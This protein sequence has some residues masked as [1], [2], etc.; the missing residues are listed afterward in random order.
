MGTIPKVTHQIW[1]QGWDQLPEKYSKN[2]ESL[3]IL[4][5]NWEH[6][7]WDEKSLRTECEKF[8]P[9]ALA[10]FDG[11][12]HMMRKIVFGRYVVLHNYGGISID[13][14]A[15]CL[16]PLDKIP[17]IS[18]E[19]LIIS[20]SPFYGWEDHLSTRGL[21][22]DLIM[23]NCATIACTKKHPLM[24]QFIEFLIKNEL[25]DSDSQFEEH[26]QTGPLVT[27]VFFNNFLDEICILECEII[28]PGGIITRRTVINH[29]YELSWAHPM[30]R[31]FK[32]PYMYVRRNIIL[33][34]ILV[35]FVMLVKWFI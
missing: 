19:S 35:Q 24:K 32:E 2:V 10:K 25:V 34:L 23:F 12:S 30:F 18:T 33:L 9:E 6:R 28:E 27:S 29:K 15:E 16:R 20:K 11:F 3:R 1:F 14:D 22:K 13:C 5:K 4:N 17:G 8:S 21:S 26:I 31:I 7:T